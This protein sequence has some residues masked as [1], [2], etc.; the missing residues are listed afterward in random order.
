VDFTFKTGIGLARF[1][2]LDRAE[3]LLEVALRMAEQARLHEFAFRIERIKNGLQAC[4]ELFDVAQ[5][6]PATAGSQHEA[7]REV[8]AQLA[9]LAP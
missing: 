8:S 3:V 6:A 7:V 5:E 1:G 9:E 4:A 2:Q